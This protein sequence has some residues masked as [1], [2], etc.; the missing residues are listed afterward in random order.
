MNLQSVCICV[1]ENVKLVLHGVE[2]RIVVVLVLTNV[3]WFNTLHAYRDS[4]L[5]ILG[6]TYTLLEHCSAKFHH[7]VMHKCMRRHRIRVLVY[8]RDDADSLHQWVT[9]VLSCRAVEH[10][11][12][13][14]EP[15]HNFFNGFVS[16]AGCNFTLS[17]LYLLTYNVLCLF[18]G[19]ELVGWVTD[20]GVGN[21]LNSSRDDFSRTKAHVSSNLHGLGLGLGLGGGSG[22]KKLLRGG[23]GSHR[24][25]EV[26]VVLVLI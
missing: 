22:S 19:R 4:F 12:E 2:F 15:V 5:S 21:R 10:V 20:V 3:L 16:V 13:R 23:T 17:S 8:F 9:R 11:N 25:L 14:L 7:T 24:H 6:E 18:D 26:E 1:G